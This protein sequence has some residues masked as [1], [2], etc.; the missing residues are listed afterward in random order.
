MDFAK[1]FLLRNNYKIIAWSLWFI[2]ATHALTYF[3]HPFIAPEQY[4]QKS[5]HVNVVF[6]SLTL[7]ALIEAAAT[8]LF[9]YFTL[10]RPAKKRTYSPYSGPA[11]F[12][13]VGFVNW[14]CSNSII[15]FGLVL[16]Y[17]SGETWPLLFFGL[18]GSVLLLFHSPRIGPFKKKVHF[19]TGSDDASYTQG[20]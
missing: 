12:I 8:V 17:M 11:R 10:I 7:V 4:I 20:A 15:I 2:C 19:E 16:Y 13:L 6:I 1:I 18:I 5:D 3:C 14:I 9:R